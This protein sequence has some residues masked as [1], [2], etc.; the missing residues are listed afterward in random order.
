MKIMLLLITYDLKSKNK[1]YSSLYDA[2]KA[3]GDYWWHYMESVWIIHTNTYNAQ[4]CADNLRALL[5]LQ[6]YLLVYDI[7]SQNYNGWLP[8][9]AWDWIRTH[10]N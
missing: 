8:S 6:D 2:I 1:D 10:N 7:T 4:S 3:S 5:D 9:K